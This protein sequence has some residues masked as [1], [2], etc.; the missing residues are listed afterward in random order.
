MKTLLLIA[1]VLSTLTA[2]AHHRH[3]RGIEPL[4]G[5]KIRENSIQIKVR[6]GGCTQ[7]SSF[8]VRRSYDQQNQL[9][10]LLFI[11]LIPDYCEAYIPEGRILT[12]SQGD[13]RLKSGQGFYIGNPILPDSSLE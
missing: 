8:V 5:A 1:T 2:Q 4:M 12:F 11:R 7:K 10:K 13:V 9:I 6:T 3:H